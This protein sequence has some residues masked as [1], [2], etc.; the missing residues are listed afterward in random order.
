MTSNR[1]LVTP[2][3][4][5]RAG[6]P[7]L[8]RLEAAGY[9]ILFCTKG[10]QPDEAE[11]LQLVPDCMGWLA[12][13]EP[14][15]ERVLES[16]KQLKAIS[17]NGTGVDS[18]DLETARRLGIRVLRAEGANARG[19][20]ELAIGLTLALVRSIPFSDRHLKAAGWERRKGIELQGRTLGLIGCG[21]IG[22]RVAV[23]AIGLGMRVVAHDPYPD[24]AFA[25]P[26]GFR[27]VSLDGVFAESDVLSLHC[28]PPGDGR[29]LVDRQH[30][31]AMKNGVYVVNTARADL[32][33]DQAV[34]EALDNGK[35]AGVALDAYRKEPPGVDPLVQHEK[36]I[37]TPHIGAFT[38]ESV[39]R[40][41]EV[42]VDNLLE[43][44]GQGD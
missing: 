26:D 40:A 17:R 6:H 34:L 22:Q 20:A 30:I 36:V 3:S 44:F 31:G 15:N 43:A 24:E 9:E 13:V 25:G 23:M 39:T 41:V 2:R 18:I 10:K 28:P 42:A 5:T 32:L 35:I 1:I 29:P 37:A 14:V 38:E 11:L 4:I 21:K 12:G 33:D 19:V 8:E 16:A 27:Y 7:A